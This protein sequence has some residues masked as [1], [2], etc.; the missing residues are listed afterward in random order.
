MWYLHAPD[1][2]TPYEVTMKVV[3]DMYKEGSVSPNT[4]RQPREE[5]KLSEL[6]KQASSS[7]LASATTPAGKWPRSARCVTRTGG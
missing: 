3:N 1:R 7:A 6:C 5:F 2:S 4:R